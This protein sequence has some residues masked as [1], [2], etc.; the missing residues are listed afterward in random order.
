MLANIRHPTSRIGPTFA[1]AFPTPMPRLLILAALVAAT[2]LPARAQFTFTGPDTSRVLSVSGF[3]RAAMDADQAV[4]RIEFETEGETVEDAIEKHQQ[5]VER[6]RALLIEAGVPESEIKL[7]RVS[8]GG[9]GGGMRFESVRPGDEAETFLASRVLVVRVDDLDLV[10]TL[11]AGAVRDD[12]DDLLDVQRRGVDVRYTVGEPRELEDE[13]L[14]KAVANARERAEL[15]VGM[16][17]LRLGEI[18][19]VTEG[20]ASPFGAE[21]AALMMMG[22]AGGSGLTDG[23]F[24]V[25]A[26]V[27]VTF[28]VQ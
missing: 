26:S 25:T 19:T 9:S 12:S 10:P 21:A 23:E 24:V 18:L 4:L 13:A 20:G 22:A 28:R 7:E 27:V 8:V 5:E 1:L 11:L 14:R 17:D 6:V 3:G 16:S 15:I 2:A